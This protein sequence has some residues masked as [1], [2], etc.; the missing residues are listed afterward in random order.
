MVKLYALLLLQ[1]TSDWAN[2]VY[3]DRHNTAFLNWLK[4][5]PVACE[6]PPPTVEDMGIDHRR[7]D[8]A[9]T[10]QL[11]DGSN[12]RADFEYVSGEGMADSLSIDEIS[13]HFS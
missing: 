9:M 5:R 2:N 12:V 11:L 10:Q 6:C 7:L 4:A 3:A 8:V 1:S 13:Q